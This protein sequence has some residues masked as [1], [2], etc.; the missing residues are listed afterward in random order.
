MQIGI[1][2]SR[3]AV[4]ARTGT[5]HYTYELIAALAQQDRQA[6]YTLYCNQPPRALP[7]LRPNFAL[8]HI[9]LPRLWTHARLSAE[10]MLHP[11]DVLFIPAHVLP[12][13]AP[14]QRRTRTVV[15][16]HDLGYLHFPE[17]HTRAQRLQLRLSTLWSARAA[18][19]LIAISAATRDDLVRF[20]GIQADKVSVV[21]HG[22]SPRFRPVDDLERL[23]AVRARYGISAPYVCYVGTIQPRKNLLRLI[24]AFAQGAREQTP[25]QLV[26]AGKRGW[27]SDAIE[28]RAAELGITEWVR[29]IGYVDDDDLPALLSGALAFTFPSLY[30]GFGMPVL[31]AMACGTPV[32]TST[33][34]SL[35][36]VAGDAALLVPPDDTAAIAAALAQLISDAALRS[37]LRKR[38]LQHVAQFTWARC[39]TQTH[40]VLVRATSGISKPHA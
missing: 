39:A 19:H 11:P 6:C 40:G 33:T 36:E 21:H 27:L 34:S 12:L 23:A 16:I 18:T 30:E 5:E 25:V 29:F 15:T 28:R 8:R 3:I 31:E 37:T 17:A 32:L 26:I 10:V 38:G 24:E 9:P 13:G 1:D 14:L 2:A 35:P 4:A 22:V 7:P 20:T